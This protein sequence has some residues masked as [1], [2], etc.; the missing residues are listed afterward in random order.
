MKGSSLRPLLR[1]AAFA[2]HVRNSKYVVCSSW[3][4]WANNMADQRSR[5][6]VVRCIGWLGAGPLMFTGQ[7]KKVA[8]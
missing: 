1:A 5:E 7:S 8:R 6:S 3:I 4:Y 2:K